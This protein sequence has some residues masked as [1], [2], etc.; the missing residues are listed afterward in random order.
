M[1][2]W[3]STNEYGELIVIEHSKPHINHDA[4]LFENLRCA[5]VRYQAFVSSRGA[6]HDTGVWVM[7]WASTRKHG[8]MVNKA[9]VNISWGLPVPV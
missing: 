6:C 7:S 4:M 1:V 5:I 9:I 3:Y 8:V 2:I